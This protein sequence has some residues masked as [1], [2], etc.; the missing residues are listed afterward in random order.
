MGMMKDYSKE[1]E[2]L[3]PTGADLTFKDAIGV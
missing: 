2:K 1:L 3:P